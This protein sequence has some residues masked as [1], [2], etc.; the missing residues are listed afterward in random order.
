MPDNEGRSRGDT[1]DK[2]NDR[3]T[4]KGVRDDGQSDKKQYKEI[5]G[6]IDKD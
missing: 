6:N 4:G 5:A 2:I 3:E 1:P